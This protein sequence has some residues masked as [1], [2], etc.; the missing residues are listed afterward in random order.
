MENMFFSKE[1]VRY[2]VWTCRDTIALIIGTR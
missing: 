2:P 1:N